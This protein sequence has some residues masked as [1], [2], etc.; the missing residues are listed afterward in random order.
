MR[1]SANWIAPWA[2][3]SFIATRPLARSPRSPAPSPADGASSAAGSRPREP[4]HESHGG[5]PDDLAAAVAIEAAAGDI[6]RPVVVPPR[7]EIPQVVVAVARHESLLEAP[8]A[9]RLDVQPER[10]LQLAGHRHP[11]RRADTDA[12]E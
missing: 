6:A 8:V 1:P 2:A 3:G 11:R 9:G 10:S 5:I 4:L 7:E 12:H